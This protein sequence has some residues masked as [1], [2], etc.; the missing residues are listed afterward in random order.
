WRGSVRKRP[1]WLTP[2]EG[3][4]LYF[5]AVWEAY[6]VQEQVWLSCAVVT[7]AAMNQRRPLIL[8]EAG[9]AAWLDPQTPLIRL[10]ELLASPSVTL[11]ERALAPF[12]N[13][14]KLD[15]PECLTPA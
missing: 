15:A 1:F 2:G 12:V 8:D 4:S 13:D 10:Q 6:A 3:A 7:Q 14:P 5:A 11:R 9:Q